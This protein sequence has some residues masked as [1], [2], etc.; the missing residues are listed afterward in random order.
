MTELRESRFKSYID[1]E[2]FASI[3]L[4]DEQKTKFLDGETVVCEAQKVLLYAP[5]SDRKKATLGV[6]TVT[7]FKLSFASAE[8]RD[9]DNCYQQNFLLGPNDA[10]LSS[11][12]TI[13]QIGDK[14]RK[15]LTPGQNVSG[16]I[17]ELL[18]ICKNMRALEFSFKLADKDSGKNVTNA[19]LHHAYPKRHSLLFA[20]DYKEPSVTSLTKEVCLFRKRENWKKELERTK[21]KQWKA[22]VVNENFQI[23]PMMMSTLIVPHS[24]TDDTLTKAVEHFRNRCCPVWV[25]GTARGAALVRMAD[26]LPTIQDRTQENTL[27]EHIRKSHPEKKQP[28]IIDLTKE[29]PSPKEIQ[30]SF[31]KLRDLCVPENTRIFKSQDF[32]FYGLLD[33]TKW[34]S[35]VSTCLSKAVEAVRQINNNTTVVLQEGNGQDLNCVISS[36]AQL[37]LDPYFRTKFGFQSLIQ[38]DWV[39]MG[40]PFGH[41]LGHILSKEVEQSPIFLLFLD[42]VWQITQQYPTAFQ[43]SETYL[44]TVWDSAH[45]S[46]FDTFLFNCEHDRIIAECGTSGHNPLILRSVWDWSEQFSEKDIALFCNPLFDDSFR[47]RLE[48][49]TSVAHLDVWMQCYFRWLPDLEIRNGGKPQVDLCNRFIVSEI[50][51]LKERIDSGEV[52][53]KSSRNKEDISELLRKVN[54]F[55]PFSRNNG[56]VVGTLPINNVLLTGDLL[57]SQSILNLN[58]D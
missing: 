45:T 40:H 4:T 41:R 8:D 22:T 14:S 30:T 49:R 44:T 5:L 36:L 58:N 46:I 47:E 13:Y 51:E 54:S 21:C 56:Q 37:M 18:I 11:I 7:T 20:Y 42:C 31:L 38:K 1:E 27:L 3:N 19:L 17:K 55:F 28:H 33:S 50:F 23:S 25:W 10:C 16:K 34:I 15:K 6:L 48:P 52:N 12:D 9:G 32:K 29:C 24:L 53:G 57:D 43:F 35:Y 2:E 39:A 26:L